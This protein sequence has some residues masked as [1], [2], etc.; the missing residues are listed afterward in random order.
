M[1]DI[2]L[3]ETTLDE[4]EVQAAARVLRSKWLTMGPEVDAF[5]T[6]FAA[7]MGAR[8]AIAV[9]NGTTALE[10]AYRAV[11]VTQ[12]TE[13][14]LPSITFVACMN[15][16]R[17][18]GATIRLADI[19]SEDDLTISVKSAA[20]LVNEH[21]RMVVSMPHGG[22]APD[23]AGLAALAK[24]RGIALVEDA[25]HAPLAQCPDWTGTLRP[26]GTFGRAATWSFFGNKN[27]T[28]GEGGMITTDDEALAKECRL[29]RSH[30]ITRPTWDRVR[31]HAF[32]Y[33][34]AASGT[35]AR[36]DELHAAVGRV[37]L[38]K[39]AA[40]NARRGRWSDA[41]R[42]GLGKR[43]IEGLVVPFATSRGTSSH[44]LF[45][46]LIPEGLERRAVMAAMKARGVQTSIHYPPLDGFTGTV[47]DINADDPIPVTRRV[48]PRILTLPLGP[49]SD[50]TGPVY[51]ERI[52]AALA[53]SISEVTKNG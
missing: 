24:E 5:E 38:R 29:L 22:H 10:L 19:V 23:M 2:P 12:G 50:E 46:A 11:G 41:M 30:G 31:G 39:L 36:M 21:T 34:V 45:V 48:G 52:V 17:N 32:D 4:E 1:F 49:W 33:D 27:M 37:Q 6:E 26:M 40:A 43:E 28:T 20:A 18:L 8:F 47:G 15:A 7:A 53:D 13:V 3:T 16:A 42:A 9:T 25:C 14:I 35:N 51:V 44:H